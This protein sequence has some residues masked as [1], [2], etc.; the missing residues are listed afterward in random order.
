MRNTFSENTIDWSAPLG[1][2]TSPLELKFIFLFY[3]WWLS[4]E[5]QSVNCALSPL[6]ANCDC[7]LD[8]KNVSGRFRVCVRT[9]TCKG[10]FKKGIS[11]I[12]RYP[13]I[14]DTISTFQFGLL[15][16]AGKKST[17]FEH[18]KHFLSGKK[19]NPISWSWGV[20]NTRYKDIF[21]CF[22]SDLS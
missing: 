22:F 10:T 18:R 3:N 1:E 16:S 15:A 8:S 9:V 2:W 11:W 20:K 12:F 6:R 7:A 13:R 21:R 17:N 4:T 14:P 19:K 5:R